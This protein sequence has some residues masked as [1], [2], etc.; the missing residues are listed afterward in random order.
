M[1]YLLA[2]FEIWKTKAQLIKER[3]AALKQRDAADARSLRWQEYAN[4]TD[5][6]FV[7]A[8]M[9]MYEIIY[10]LDAAVIYYTQFPKHLFERQRVFGEFYKEA[11]RKANKA[12]PHPI[13]FFNTKERP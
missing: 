13:Q 3:N 10:R 1:H 8:Y 11:S 9:A 2:L 5:Q 4:D 12:L 7:D 6:H